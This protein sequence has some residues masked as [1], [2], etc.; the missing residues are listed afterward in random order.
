[1]RNWL[2]QGRE[3]AASVQASLVLVVGHMLEEETNW[4]GR[5]WAQSFQHRWSSCGHGQSGCCAQQEQKGLT[6]ALGHCGGDGHIGR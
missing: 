2:G 3:A 1:M 5:N 6:Q 4:G